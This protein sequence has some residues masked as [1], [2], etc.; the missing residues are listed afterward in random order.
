MTDHSE[1][2]RCFAQFV[3]QH[4]L[5]G[6]RLPIESL[7]AGRPD[8]A[9]PLR[10]LVDRY[11]DLDATLDGGLA[12][13]E[14][15]PL[16]AAPTVATVATV[17][18]ALPAFE[19]FRTIERIGA[20]G[21]GEVYKLHDLTLERFVAAKVLRRRG[22]STAEVL[23]EARSLALFSDRR[24]VQIHEVREDASPPVIIMELVEGFELG[25][26]GPSLEPRQRARILVDVC[27]AIQQA[28]DRGLQHRDLK[29]SN[30]MLD[31]NLA[32]KILDFGLSDR[33]PSRGHLVGTPHYLAPEQLDPAAPIDARTDVYALGVV[34][35]ELLAGVVPYSGATAADVVDALRTR[36]PRLPVE[37][38]PRVP[39]PLQAIALKAMERDPAQR[40]Q[41]AR[42][43]GLDLQRYLDGRPVLARPTI[44]A[45]TLGSRVAP[46]LHHIDEWLRLKL[47]YRHEAERLRAAYR[48][49]EK[50]EDDWIV[51]TRSLSYSQIALYLGAFLLV[52]G[53]LFY[54]GA[55]RVYHAV[56]GVARPFAVLA[57]PFL[58]LNA[59][60]RYLYRRDHKAVAVGLLLAGV[61]L[62]PLFLL[63]LFHET[64]WWVVAQQTPGQIFRDG[65]VSNRQLQITVAIAC[66]WSMW[67]ALRTRTAA[68]S[69]VAAVLMLLLTVA[70]LGDAGLRGWLVEGRLDRL[71]LHVAPLAAVYA[72]LGAGS[73][74]TARPW[75]AHPLYL[76]AVLVGVVSLD[77]LA[78]DGRMFGYVGLSLKPFQSPSVSSATLLD[79]CVALTLNGV[80][81]YAAAAAMERVGSDLVRRA[82]RMLFTIAPF[83]MLEPLGYLSETN[84]YSRRFDWLYL[85]FAFA[86]VVA[87]HARQRKSFYYAG[88]LNTGIALYLIADHRKWFDKPAWGVALIACGLAAMAA[89]YAFDRR[90][91]SGL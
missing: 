65:S 59:A 51:E 69:T 86:I 55:D 52:S 57:V 71:A 41:S 67:L 16:R 26:L 33:D 14:G 42:E 8:L 44:Y 2:E 10:A 15:R 18:E 46:H 80:A 61:G 60:G 70:L 4:V 35:Y 87:S 72:A 29:P 47:V 11:L 62:L 28:H 38:D 53:S 66:G 6:T 88:L 39:E 48:E 91:R 64:G 76:G 22:P 56:R 27:D 43:M 73:E 17:P 90:A 9:T 37:I 49:L 40:Y 63:I 34:L 1:L 23:R 20:G 79:T 19:G 50:R 12:A 31:A 83:S 54:F 30:I 21:M 68:L 3:E 58:C 13:P 74:R 77:L 36:E 25:R 24:I 45:S 89:G 78:L 32:P 7:V 81:F 85:A 84:E 5:D 75:L 82:A